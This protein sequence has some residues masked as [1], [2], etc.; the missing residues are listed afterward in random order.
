M[1]M[2]KMSC[3]GRNSKFALSGEAGVPGWSWHLTVRSDYRGFSDSIAPRRKFLLVAPKVHPT[4][5]SDCTRDIE[6]E[7]RLGFSF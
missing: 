3:S 7:A 2:T 4:I 1:L 5:P 6:R